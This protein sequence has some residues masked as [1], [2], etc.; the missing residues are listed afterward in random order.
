M[1][2]LFVKF[3]T[4]FLFSFIL[5]VLPYTSVFGTFTYNLKNYGINEGLPSV[6]IYQIIQ[7]K[8]GYIWF[9]TDRGL[10]KYN[11]SNF[12]VYTTED[13]LSSNVVY[14]LYENDQNEIWC[15]SKDHQLHYYHKGKFFPFSYNESIIKY[16]PKKG[17]LLYFT[18][19]KEEAS[20]SVLNYKTDRHYFRI[21]K[22]GLAF[23]NTKKGIFIKNDS[24]ITTVSLNELSNIY[25][26]D[27]L[28]Y[29]L[30]NEPIP[31]K[32][33]FASSKKFSSVT[34]FKNNIYISVVNKIIKIDL[35]KKK[36]SVIIE[37]IDKNI[38]N[39]T[40]DKKG[41]I[42]VSHTKGITW[43]KENNLK[44]SYDILKNYNISNILIGDNDGLWMAS[45]F[46]GLFQLSNIN[47]KHLFIEKKTKIFGI[48][49]VNGKIYFELNSN[50]LYELSN[51]QVKKLRLGI[52]DK[53]DHLFFEPFY[54]SFT[55]K[56]SRYNIFIN[57]VDDAYFKSQYYAYKTALKDTFALSL[58]TNNA[59]RYESPQGYSISLKFDKFI[60]NF[61]INKNLI[62]IAT[63][64][65]V[66]TLSTNDIKLEL[67]STL[68]IM[69]STR[70]FKPEVSFLASNI[71]NVQNIND[72][73]V[74]FSS[75]KKGLCRYNID[76]NSYQIYSKK[77]GLISN[78]ILKTYYKNGVTIAISQEGLSL[79]KN[80]EIKNYSTHNSLLSN[81]I[82]GVVLKNDTL[83]VAT[84]QG[85][86]VIPV[87]S[88]Q[89]E[90]PRV[91]LKRLMVD[92]TLQEIKKNYNLDHTGK[93]LDIT[94][95]SV[96]YY[97]S[98]NSKYQYILEG[99]DK[100]W[101]E[102]KSTHVRYPNLPSGN[103]KFFIRTE[104]AD[105]SWSAK[106]ELFTV[107]KPA[108]FWKK[109]WF[110]FLIIILAFLISFLIFALIN[111]RWRK[112]QAEKINILNLERKT[113]QAQINPH[114]IFNSLTSLQNLILKNE[115]E[116]SQ[117]FLIHFSRLT[118]LALNH[119]T[120]NY[121]L[122][123]E[124]IE[125]LTLYMNLEK[126]RFIQSF[127]FEFKFDL[128]HKNIKIPPLLV[129]PF[130]EN[131]ILHGFAGFESGGKI[132][133]RFQK[134]DEHTIQCNIRD[135][136][137]GRN[138]HLSS[139]NKKSL[140]IKLIKE[141][142]AILLNEPAIKIVDLEQHGKQ[143]GTEVNIL[144]PIIPILHESFNN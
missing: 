15:Y 56:L 63:D 93:N 79:I 24:K 121:I 68:I 127:S 115:K 85:I 130:I 23:E 117:T 138:L 102:T 48:F 50:E 120:K 70:V 78:S 94:F 83:W 7:D 73:I 143:T 137:N 12:T 74:L 8:S 97:H 57:Q 35:S 29:F 81:N 38:Q 16:F 31:D 9:G 49:E 141:R 27:T 10:V 46:N 40:C 91:Y 62:L 34:K 58:V 98:N 125:F 18:A 69:D 36:A 126:I 136:G 25:I 17:D 132:I 44:E 111:L 55:N 104:Q 134:R 32:H 43:F 53:M 88:V 60:K 5:I 101:I 28:I 67:D 103:F 42:F 52:L 45:L 39:I 123:S 65:F 26:N 112:K 128:I 99:V 80:S 3:A 89:N 124:E 116:K 75:S 13:G 71:V 107:S 135:N 14:H 6:Q 109:N 92:E 54:H 106:I 108:P 22:N 110:I 122:L 51:Q 142:L 37:L 118:R 82:I 61:D 95:E 47:Q 129:Q 144:I 30:G 133:I 90:K 139:L 59:M 64:N 119:S 19:N 41:N 66:H 76:D 11:G 2:R 140:G 77:N 20:I 131:A 33:N 113:L 4:C 87:N 86:S 96:S 21:N 100:N 114:F 1:K 84:D 72:S 105:K